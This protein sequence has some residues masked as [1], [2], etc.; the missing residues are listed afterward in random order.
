MERF[1]Y[2]DMN[3]IIGTELCLPSC[4]G[5]E[6]QTSITSAP[7]RSCDQANLGLT[8]FCNIDMET[9]GA[10]M[11]ADLVLEDYK[12]A[13]PNG[14]M[15]SY[16]RHINSPHRPVPQDRFQNKSKP[17]TYNAFDRDVAKVVFYF[18]KPVAIEY[19]S[20]PRMTIAEYVANVGGLLG[21]SSLN[22][23]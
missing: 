17:R 1:R 6:Y 14:S 2:I 11:W 13:Y 3:K 20:A 12:R 23:G 4:E 7:Y 10:H 19:V 8:E 22:N 15:P 9:Q 21:R 5:V 16:L 18:S